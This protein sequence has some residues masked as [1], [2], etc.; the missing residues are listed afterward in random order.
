M[1]FSLATHRHPALSNAM[2]PAIFKA[3]SKAMFVFHSV[4]TWN[5]TRKTRRILASLNDHML[6]DIGLTRGD[7]ARM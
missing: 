2:Q 6:T 7:I 4:I 5:Q 3:V 1:T